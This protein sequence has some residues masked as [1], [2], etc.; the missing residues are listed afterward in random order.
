MNRIS[1]GP[2]RVK[3]RRGEP[4]SVGDAGEFLRD[5]LKK[6]RGHVGGIGL[7]CLVAVNEK[8]GNRRREDTCLENVP[9][10]LMGLQ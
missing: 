9:K 6:S 2:K 3:G 1:R 4:I 5:L 7:E 10:T 8:C